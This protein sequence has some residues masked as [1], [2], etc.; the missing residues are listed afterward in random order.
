MIEAYKIAFGT[1]SLGVTVAAYWVYF[2]KILNEPNIRPQPTSW[3]IWGLVTLIAYVMQ[4][5]RGAGPGSWTTLLTVAA[6]VEIVYMA[7]RKKKEDWRFTWLDGTSLGLA[8]LAVSC[9]AATRDPTYAAVFAT[10]ADVIGYGPTISKS[11]SDPYSDS[12]LA[13]S[14][15]AAKFIVALPALWPWSIATSLY[16]LVVAIM[17]SIVTAILLKQRRESE[18]RS[19]NDSSKD[20]ARGINYWQ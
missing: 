4:Q 16:P 19:L 18:G 13:F 20:Q 6:C 2:H 17:N 7:I 10:L 8:L 9:Y 11:W 3:L 5:L 15:N 1:V 12:A 14:L